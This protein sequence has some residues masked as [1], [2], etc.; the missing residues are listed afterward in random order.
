MLEVAGVTAVLAV[1]LTALGL[2]SALALRARRDGWVAVVADAPLH[3]LVWLP[4]GVVGWTWLSW[5]GLSVVSATWGAAVVAAVRGLPAAGSVR[6]RR[7]AGRAVARG[8]AWA[9]VLALAVVV[10]LRE[11]N[12]LPWMG[13]MGAYVNWSNELVRTGELTAT[14]PPLFSAY[15]SVSTAFFGTAHTT[16]GM[17][18]V[19]LVLVVAVARLAGRLGAGPWVEL[20]A[21]ATLALQLHAVWY[22]SFPTSESLTAPL[23]VLW[24]GLLHRAVLEPA[25]RHTVAVGVALLAL[26]MLRGSAGMLL[27]PLGLALLLAVV[28]R[29]W[30]PLARP[31]WAATGASIVASV[32]AYWYGISEIRRYFVDIQL[33]EVLPA[34]LWRRL[35][36]LTLFDPSWWSA[37]VL[38]G[39]VLVVRLVG[40]LAVRRVTRGPGDDTGWGAA[41]VLV[42]IAA[43]TV[44][45]VAREWAVDGEVWQILVRMGPALLVGAVVATAAAG[46]RRV[47][48]DQ[49]AVLLAA[50][51][52]LMFLVLHASRLGG[53]R[54]HSF[55]LYWDRYLVSEVLPFSVVLA[56]AGLG[57]ALRPAWRRT[58]PDEAQGPARVP[59][60]TRALRGVAALTGA[61]A[62][63]VVVV[64]GLP[65]LRQATDDVFLRGAYPLTVELLDIVAQGQGPAYWSADSRSGVENFTAF[66]NTWMAFAVP[67]GRTFGLDVVNVNR[68]SVRDFGPDDVL[69]ANAV[70]FTAACAEVDTFVLL[71]VQTG[72]PDAPERLAAPGISVEPI[73]LVEGP[74]LFLGQP[75][76]E[77]G[78]YAVDFRVEAWQVTVAPEARALSAPCWH[79]GPSGGG[80]RLLSR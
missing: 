27:A 43:A 61:A 23:T 55:Y 53:A 62:L 18:V 69:Q 29:A 54:E 12:F 39:G 70:A 73:G 48:A 33:R 37:G 32:V 57:W 58:P 21:A 16:A 19:G 46:W 26:G 2:P 65:A 41:I 74:M 7:P 3:G 63:A 1:L 76:G 25:R 35:D 10:R 71:D 14:W 6:P 64:P 4:L 17:A 44:A 78:W 59:G 51:V 36:D 52:M 60:R 13:D 68:G 15:L 80:A 50:L 45:V 11:V 38:V 24:L 20:A 67:L 66:P 42:A 79:V 28:V 9:A 75:A 8:A 49:L 77:R 22:S 31:L 40:T 34:S 30:R 72:G 47:R 5:W 56:F